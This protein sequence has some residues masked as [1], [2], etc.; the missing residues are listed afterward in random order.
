VLVLAPGFGSDT[1][2]SI[3]PYA[4]RTMSRDDLVLALDIAGGYLT[5][6]IL[7]LIVSELVIKPAL[8]RLYMRADDLLA[9][10]LPDIR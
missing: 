5:G 4:A 6:R 9:D 10:R 2:R 3:P 1:K 7:W 8:F